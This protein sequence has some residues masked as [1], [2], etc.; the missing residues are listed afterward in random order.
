MGL[1]AKSLWGEEGGFSLCPGPP[2][3]QRPLCLSPKPGGCVPAGERGACARAA[4]FL[5]TH[6]LFFPPLLCARPTSLDG[7]ASQAQQLPNS[8]VLWPD[9]A[10]CLRK[11]KRHARP[12]PFARLSDLCHRQLP[13]DQTA[14]LNSVDHDDP[15]HATL[16]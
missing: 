10:V 6:S 1:P 13:E 4:V 11:K 9:E 5:L 3:T 15:G 7:P 12:D 14:I 16:L 2:Y 8:Q